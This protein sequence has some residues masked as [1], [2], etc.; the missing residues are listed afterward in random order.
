MRAV[1]RLTLFSDA[2][3]A[4]A[5]TLLALDLPVPEGDSFSAF[6]SS[7]REND[8]HY[9]AFLISFV[10]IAAAWGNHHDVFRYLRRTSPRLRTFDMAWLMTIVLNP[11]A[12]RLLTSAGNPVLDVHAVRFGFYA[13]LQVAE[14]GVLLSMMRHMIARGLAPELPQ[15]AVTGLT[16][17]SYVLMAAFGVSIPIFFVTTYGWLLW[18]AGPL[19]EGQLKRLRRLRRLRRERPRR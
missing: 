1:D 12:T 10:V 4:I 9:A 19:A 8:G 5:I 18:L 7:V 11:F 2:V 16:R 15:S 13:L 3:V 6:W 17:Q 14:S